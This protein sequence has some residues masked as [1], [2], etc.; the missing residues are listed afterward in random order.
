[1]LFIS[2]ALLLLI[3]DRAPL[4]LEKNCECVHLR[5][6]VESYMFGITEQ[7]ASGPYVYRVLI[8][9]LLLGTKT[10]LTFI[11]FTGID[12]LLKV[13]LLT[14][15]QV[16]LFY[17]LRIFFSS[18]VS[19]MGVVILDVLLSFTFSSIMG[20]SVVETADIFNL[21]IFILALFTLQKNKFV[22]F[23]LL[24]FV[25]TFNRETTW[26]LLPVLFLNDFKNKKGFYRT[27]IA[28]V[29]IAVPYFG[30]RLLIHSDDAGWFTVEKFSQNIPFLSG[31]FTTK[32]L[33]ANFHTA[34]FLLP[35]IILTCINFKK[36]PDFLRT[37]IYVTPLFIV[38]HYL[39]GSIIETRLWLPLVIILLPTSLNTILVLFE[40]QNSIQLKEQKALI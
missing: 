25:G 35:L 30:L 8:P 2:F 9:Y 1:M 26:F 5:Q 38:V 7:T 3:A 12:F 16:Y 27:M 32:A 36:H 17:Y 31:G 13:L 24:I 6:N 18:L 37:T 34:I 21:A 22:L 11:S 14:I 10:V 19:I 28:F 4:H 40:E 33:I 23:L 39:L 29:V 15:C 20:P